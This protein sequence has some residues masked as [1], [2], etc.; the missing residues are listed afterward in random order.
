MFYHDSY[1]FSHFSLVHLL[2]SVMHSATT[3]YHLC[4]KQLIIVGKIMNYILEDSSPFWGAYFVSLF[5]SIIF[6][7]LNLFILFMGY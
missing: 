5:F 3:D 2:L 6:E 1:Y 7:S 4:V